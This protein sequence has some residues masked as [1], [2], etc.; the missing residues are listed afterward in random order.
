MTTPAAAKMYE[1][2]HEHEMEGKGNAFYN[3]SNKPFEDLPVIY[4]FNNGG[5]AGW[6]GAVLIA[7]D[8]MG[9]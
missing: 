5:S 2:Q 7:E 1:A 3:P 8:G 6:Y 9:L 4:G